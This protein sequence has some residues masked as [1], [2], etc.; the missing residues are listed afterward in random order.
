METRAS[1]RS[2]LNGTM[3]PRRSSRPRRLQDDEKVKSEPDPEWEWTDGIPD[4][5]PNPESKK[6]YAIQHFSASHG[7]VHYKIGDVVQIRGTRPFKWVA[8]IRGFEYDTHHRNETPL[9]RK[10]VIVLWFCR[11]GDIGKTWRREDGHPVPFREVSDDLRLRARY[12][13]RHVKT[14][15]SSPRS[16]DMPRYTHHRNC[17]GST[18]RK[19][20]YKIRMMML[21]TCAPRLLSCKECTGGT[22]IGQIS[23]G[24][25]GPISTE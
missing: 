2:S 22:S 5:N 17:I 3:A 12:T 23:I 6:S 8:L 18:G 9:K 25:T 7:K 16:S 11:Q 14:V 21:P 13:F 15:L 24:K 1:R 4:I 20:K 10:R 19:Q